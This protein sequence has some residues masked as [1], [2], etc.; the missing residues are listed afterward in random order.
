MDIHPFETLKVWSESPLGKVF[1]QQERAALSPVLSPIRG[2]FLVWVGCV[3]DPTLIPYLATVMPN[4]EPI[5]ITKTQVRSH[6]P[7][8]FII[9]NKDMYA[10]PLAEESVECII[11]HHCLE[12]VDSPHEVLQEAHRILVPE[13]TLIVSGFNPWSLWGS[14]RLVAHWLG[15]PP[16]WQGRFFS[17]YTLKEW[18]KLLS[19]SAFQTKSFFYLPP[20]QN[21]SLLGKFW[22]LSKLERYSSLNLGGGFLLSAKKRVQRLIPIYR[23]IEM[24]QKIAGLRT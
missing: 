11:L 5:I 3:P 7:A 16:P 24:A 2:R 20:I 8:G 4:F 17:L 1:F 14:W 6:P 21:S 19:F 13:G 23:K 18:L 12:F 9:W 22:F 10:L 15:L